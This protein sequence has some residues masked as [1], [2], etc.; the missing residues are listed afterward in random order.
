MVF[1]WNHQ[2][3]LIWIQNLNLN[4]ASEIKGLKGIHGFI[5]D[6]ETKQMFMLL[7]GEK[8]QYW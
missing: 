3:Q 4:Q 1:N 6:H 7:M 2:F 5:L 8:V